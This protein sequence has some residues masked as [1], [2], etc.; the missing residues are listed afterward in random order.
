MACEFL[1]LLAVWQ[2]K[3]ATFLEALHMFIDAQ[4]WDT[5]IASVILPIACSHITAITLPHDKCCDVKPVRAIPQY[6]TE[7][8]RGGK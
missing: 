3:Y 8:G 7:G 4:F 5:P 6:I 1:N 2:V